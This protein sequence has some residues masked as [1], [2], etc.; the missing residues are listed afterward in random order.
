MSKGCVRKERRKIE[1]S[2]K[3]NTSEHLKANEN[4]HIPYM[5]EAEWFSFARV[6]LMRGSDGLRLER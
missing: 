5:K 4:R 2:N 6:Q 1:L 3:R